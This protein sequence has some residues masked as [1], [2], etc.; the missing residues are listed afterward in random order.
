MLCSGDFCDVYCLCRRRK[1]R[2]EDA[3]AQHRRRS[4]GKAQEL[5]RA[6]MAVQAKELSATTDRLSAERALVS[7]QK[8]K[9][10]QALGATVKVWQRK[11]TAAPLS[12]G[13][14]DAMRTNLTTAKNSL[15][16]NERLL[17]TRFLKEWYRITSLVWETSDEGP[18]RLVQQ[19]NALDQK[20][21]KH[22]TDTLDVCTNKEEA[23][24][25][26]SSRE[27]IGTTHH[28]RQKSERVPSHVGKNILTHIRDGTFLLLIQC[29]P[30]QG[31]LQQRQHRPQSAATPAAAPP[32]RAASRCGGKFSG[33]CGPSA[34]QC[35]W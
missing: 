26:T 25:E 8:S 27:A 16:R 14:R 29:Q 18:A 1:S 30:D 32:D 3:E 2:G 31:E 28:K 13:R 12:A 15:Q 11:A 35:E 20:V 6:F 10:A 17:P 33:C 21:T 24:K 9:F 4:S 34:Q 7:Y 19:L 23:A 5:D 22:L